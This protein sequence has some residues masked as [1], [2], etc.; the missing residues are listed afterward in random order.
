[1]INFLIEWKVICPW[2]ITKLLRR[3]T[4][5]SL[6]SNECCAVINR[7]SVHCVRVC[8]VCPLKPSYNC[9]LMFHFN[10]AKNETSINQM[11]ALQEP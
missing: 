9:L 1:M 2:Q 6:M 11:G 3:M 8:T 10:C 5:V 4:M 7:R